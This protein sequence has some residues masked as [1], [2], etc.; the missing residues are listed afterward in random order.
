MQ[1][2]ATLI[3][4]LISFAI[5]VWF[6]MKFIWPLITSTLTKRQKMIADGLAAANRSQQELEAAQLKVLEMVNEAKQ[7]GAQILESAQQRANRV[8]EEA[9]E[10]AQEESQRIMAQA[11]ADISTEIEA[12]RTKLYNDVV[13]LAVQG[14]QKIIG[15]DIN[16]QDSQ[17]LVL[18]LIG[19]TK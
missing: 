2:N 10:R 18:D 7:Q 12:A 1:I 17:R 8:I 9:K 13:D 19:R 11:R 14:A 6:C 3:G 15:R 16:N 4:Q 5:F